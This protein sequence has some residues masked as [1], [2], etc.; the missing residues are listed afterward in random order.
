MNRPGWILI[1]GILML[2]IGGCGGVVADLKQIKTEE[3][4]AFVGEMIEEIQVEVEHSELEPNDIVA[5]KK[6][7]PEVELS[8]SDTIL[9][10]D[11]IKSLIE[12]AT[13]MSPE[14]K[15][16]I[17]NHGYLGIVISLTYGI[18]GILFFSWKDRRIVNLTY[19]ILF[20]SLIFVVYQFV[21]LNNLEMSSIFK[22]GQKFNLGLGGIFDLFLLLVI[23]I[24]DKTYFSVNRITEDHYDDKVDDYGTT[25]KT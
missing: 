24:S 20:V 12:S 17:V 6:L 8:E 4:V 7:V 18:I 3:L 16:A 1:V 10:R 14:A 23:A 2:M 13:Y 22:V 15:K 25:Y 5:I 11:K 9:S 21:S 19:G